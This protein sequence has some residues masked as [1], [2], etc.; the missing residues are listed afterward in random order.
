MIVV[1]AQMLVYGG[2]SVATSLG[3]S[4]WVIGV[5]IIAAGTSLPEFATSL[6]AVLKGRYGIGLGNIVGSDIFNV[7][8]VLGLTGM[9]RVVE[10]ETSATTSLAGLC[11]MV[12]I[13][14]LF[15]RTGWRLSRKEGLL[16]MTF[17]SAR[18]ILDLA[19]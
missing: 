18:W 9:I 19:S 15:M 3:L 2:T 6:V 10:V 17:A 8:G 4:D 16:L 7:L 11:L 5:T 1:A 14:V 13:T 12:L